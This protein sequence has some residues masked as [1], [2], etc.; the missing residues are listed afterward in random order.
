MT[1]SG[2][3]AGNHEPSQ[4]DLIGAVSGLQG[5][6]DRSLGEKT[7]RVVMASAGVMQDQKAGRKRIR[8]WAIAATLVVFF[9]VAPPIWWLIENLIE[10]Q[11]LNSTFGEIA[12]WGFF[13]I[14]ALLGSALLAGW[15]RRRS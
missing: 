6:R 7:R 10:E 2:S 14:T 15:L 9:I 4:S 12:I 8:A 1:P 11:H 3:V 13:S 5:D